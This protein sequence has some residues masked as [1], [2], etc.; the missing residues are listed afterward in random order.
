MKSN[1][2][3]ALVADAVSLYSM[4]PQFKQ[5]RDTNDTSSYSKNSVYLGLLASTLW[6][7]YY[8]RRKTYSPL[9]LGVIG[10]SFDLY[11]LYK[12]RKQSQ[13]PASSPRGL[14]GGAGFVGDTR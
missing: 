9:F 5:L 2:L 10:I 14:S 7:F 8:V 4:Y 11:I 1:E 6:M 13:E 3:L 12:L